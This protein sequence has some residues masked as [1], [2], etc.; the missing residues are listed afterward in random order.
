MTPFARLAAIEYALGEGTLTTNDLVKLFPQGSVEK[1][2]LKTGINTR[3]VSG[4]SEFASDLAVAAA[5]KL[6]ASGA[7]DP[8]EIDFLLLCTQTGDYAIPSTA[9]LVQDRLNL[10]C[11][12]GALDFSIGCS[13]YVYGLGLA[14]GLVR[15][16][17]AR[18][19]LLLT[20]DT[21]TKYLDPNDRMSRAIF[22]DAAAATLI[23]ASPIQSFVRFDYGTDGKGAKSLIAP[24]S[25]TR[26][27]GSCMMEQG[28]ARNYIEMNGSDI[29]R[30]ATTVVPN[31]VRH[32]LESSDLS[33]AD[34]D[35]FIFHQANAFLLEELRTLLSI[36]AERFQVALSKCGN[37]IASSIPIAL[38]HAMEEKRPLPGDLILLV[39]F[40][41][42]LSWSAT[43]L[44]W[45]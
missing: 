17:Q 29:F 13:G 1:S 30:F 27:L 37:T 15:S 39:G 42:G 5:E 2:D 28:K 25:G 43:I 44:R 19:L 34:I 18:K 31:L 7:C 8:K 9:C 35:L 11:T 32:T 14:E 16:G 36:P 6:F 33:V 10:P 12:L 23:E 20:A 3:R 38:K 41:V 4:P 45:L 21:Y 22:G 24:Q 26:A 40:G